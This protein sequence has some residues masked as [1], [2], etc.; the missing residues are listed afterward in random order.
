MASLNFQK[1]FRSPPLQYCPTQPPLEAHSFMDFDW[2]GFTNTHYSFGGACI[3][4]ADGTIAYKYCLQP[5]VSLYST[6]AKFMAANDLG[7]MHLFFC[8]VLWDISIPQ[9]AASEMYEDNDA[10]TAKTPH[11]HHMDIK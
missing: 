11:T 6:E 8:S 2:T 4:L 5:T 3:F 7:K 9:H 10:C 1:S